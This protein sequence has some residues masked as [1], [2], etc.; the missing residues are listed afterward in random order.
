MDIHD[1]A[2]ALGRRH[3]NV[4]KYLK[5]L[6]DNGDVIATAPQSSTGRKYLLKS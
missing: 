5:Q 2:A 1:I 6:V 3:D 4:R